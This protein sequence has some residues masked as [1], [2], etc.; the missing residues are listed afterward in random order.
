MIVG[1]GIDLVDVERIARSAESDA[2][3]NKT[4]TPAEI[5]SCEGV[6]DVAQHLAGKFAA[7]EALMKA[8]GSGIRQGV[9]FRQIEVLSGED[10]EPILTASGR[11]AE[12]LRDLGVEKTHVS[13]SHTGGYAIGLVVLE[14]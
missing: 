12:Y 13:I 4:F 3:L 2:F 6:A 8:L 1:V 10:G 14:K 9:W 11:A 7:K 5:A